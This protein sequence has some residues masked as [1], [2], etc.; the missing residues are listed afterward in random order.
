MENIDLREKKITTTTFVGMIVNAFLS[1]C[2]ILAGIFG[3]SAAMI[4]DGI[5][6][7][8]DFVSDIIVLLFVKISSKGVDDDHDYGHGKFETLASLC[9]SI[10]LFFVSVELFIS[11][12]NLI[13]DYFHGKMIETP[14]YI[15]L[16]MAFVSIVVKEL[17]F[18][19][20]AY[21]GKTVDSSV[22]VANA[23]HHRTDALSSVASAL[24]ITGA[25]LLGEKWCVLD[26]IVCCCISLFI[27]YVA[28]KMA[29]PSLQEL[30]EVSLPKEVEDE[31]CNVI[32]SVDGVESVH[33]VKTRKSGPY[34]IIEAHIVVNPHLSIV[35]AHDIA[36]DTEKQLRNKYGSSTH[37]N[38]HVEP[39]ED[40]E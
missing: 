23:W 13:I 11:G 12:I 32:N 19:Y 25:I 34:I 15:A 26:P 39:S 28:V 40:A 38:L 22:V 5:H 14:G 20:T 8:S 2:K 29:L 27:F 10:L 30:L 21:V 6:S 37:I 1:I 9:I 31:M 35:R 7:I 4:A 18:Q 3:H 17:L 24:G 16:I 36:T 33:S